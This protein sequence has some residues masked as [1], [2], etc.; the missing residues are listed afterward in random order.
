MN[1]F[2]QL[3]WNIMQLEFLPTVIA[4]CQS[5]GLMKWEGH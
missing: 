2:M 4:V 3:D 5:F 1:P